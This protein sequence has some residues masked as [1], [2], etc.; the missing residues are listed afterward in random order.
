MKITVDSAKVQAAIEKRQWLLWKRTAQVGYAAPY[1]MYVHENLSMPHPRG[2]QAKFLEQPARMYAPQIAALVKADLAAGRTLD[3]A[4][5][6]GGKYLL[7][8]S[9][10]L[11]PVLTGQLKNS[12]FVRV[13]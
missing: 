13:V 7:A 4:V 6:S 1:A 8:Q 9:R 11:V 3:E 12:G 5:L 2:G 10:K